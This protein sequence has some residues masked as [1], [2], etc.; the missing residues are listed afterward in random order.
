S[1]NAGVI[2]AQAHLQRSFSGARPGAACISSGTGRAMGR[3]R[4]K[5]IRKR[6]DVMPLPSVACG[7]N[8]ARPSMVQVLVS[9]RSGIGGY[10]VARVPWPVLLTP[11][12]GAAQRGTERAFSGRIGQAIG[13]R[14]GPRSGRG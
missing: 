10:F 1:A 14:G 13:R 9:A 12:P 5:P 6:A 11:F 2:A 4:G 8:P 7:A 3:L